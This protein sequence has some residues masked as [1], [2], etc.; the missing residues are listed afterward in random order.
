MASLILKPTGKYMVKFYRDKRPVHMMLPTGNKKQAQTILN[1]VD[2][3]LVQIKTG[4]PDRVLDNWVAE[5]SDDM[6]SRFE[7]CGLLDALPESKVFVDVSQEYL[8]TKAVVWK[9][10]TL[11]HRTHEHRRLVEFF[12]NKAI[13]TITKRDSTALL[14]WLV[15]DQKL[16]PIS[17]NKI[18]KLAGSVYDFAVDNEYISKANPFNGVRV[19]NKVQR[20]KAYI[21]PEYTEKLIES[22]PTVAWKTMIALLRYGGLRPAEAIIARWSD[23]DWEANTFTF[24]SPKTERHEGKEQRT[25]PLFPR[26]KTAL[27]EAQKV[28]S[29]K[30]TY[31]LAGNGW[32][33]KRQAIADGKAGT[34]C[35][36]TDFVKKAGLP[37]PGSIPTNMRG[38]CSTDLK[39]SF[40]EF[41]VDS[42]LGHSSNIAHKHYDVVTASNMRLATEID[43]FSG[44]SN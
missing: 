37:N 32:D 30:D 38:S 34:L 27:E 28:A 6:R 24:R 17:V 31:I 41:V 5:L 29:N 13:D 1:M 22:C 8:D 33:S 44:D 9:K 35:E 12:G 19:P 21:S 36:M 23:V 25:I 10:L 39:Q 15:S 7:R 40:P 18:L 43:V 42:W 26:L 16:A 20:Q 11:A 2:R 3:R 4:E 14:N